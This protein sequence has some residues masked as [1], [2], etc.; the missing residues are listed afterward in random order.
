F[1]RVLFRSSVWEFV[2][3]GGFALL[4]ERS[5]TMQV[6][7]YAPGVGYNLTSEGEA[8][9]LTGAT[10][11]GDLFSVLGAAPNLGRVFTLDDQK[12]AQ[13]RT[14]IL[15]DALWRERF[16]ADRNIVGGTIKLEDAPVQVVGVMP[17]G[18][19]FPS[20]HTQLWVADKIDAS[21]PKTLWNA[22]WVML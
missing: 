11:S 13:P 14:A 7:A 21:D 3:K 1:R 17:A 16:G 10:V 19:A 5:H 18:F 6:A 20:R 12:P 22:S 8:V 2:P 4:R 15:S 9:R